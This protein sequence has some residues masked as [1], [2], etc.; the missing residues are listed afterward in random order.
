MQILPY[1]IQRPSI[2]NIVH[3][4]SLHAFF[5]QIVLHF[6]H[7]LSPHS[8]LYNLPYPVNQNWSDIQKLSTERTPT[9]C[10]DPRFRIFLE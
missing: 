7:I 1:C 3:S 4:F 6:S 10:L 9:M 8:N 5:T 2:T